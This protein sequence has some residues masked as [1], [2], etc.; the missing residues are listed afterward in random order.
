MNGRLSA[1]YRRC[2]E[3]GNHRLRSFAGGR[4]APYCRPTWIAILLTELC[5]ARCVHCDI[6]KNRGKED[7]PTLSQWKV[8]LSDL[9]K[10]LGP[11][12]ILFTGGEALLRP[13]AID[14]VRHASSNGLYVEHLTHGYWEDQSKIEE[15]ALAGAGCLTVSL[16]AIG[17]VHS[18]IRGREN[19]YEKTSRTIET[20]TRVRRERDLGYT[21]RLKTVIMNQ[22]LDHVCEVAHHA[23][24]GGMEAF[25]QPI[26]QNYNTPEDLTWYKNSENWPKDPRKAVE[27]VERLIQLKREGFPISNSYTQLEVMIPYFRDPDAWQLATQS[28]IAHERRFSCAAL[29]MLQVQA[30]GDVRTCA[31]QSPVGNIKADPIRAIWANRP[32]WWEGGCCFERYD[33]SDQK[34]GDAGVVLT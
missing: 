11:V 34:K 2:Y 28:H 32:H 15:L 3:G 29:E 14:L 19:F 12:H 10:W 20:L 24:Q 5:N 22:N 4:W 8:F 6:W 16:D 9:R 13:F 21:I 18:K 30:N 23:R 33:G 25:Y 7:S 17:E 27:T 1:I 26:E 31:R